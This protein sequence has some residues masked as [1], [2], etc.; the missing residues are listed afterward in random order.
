MYLKDK[1]VLAIGASSD[2]AADLNNKL[3]EAGA[4]IGLHYNKND[5][6]LA[7][8]RDTKTIRKF[9]KDLNSS[10][11]CHE[12][13][14][15]FVKWAGG[16][17]CL[18]Q[19]SGDI[20]NPVHW[21]ELTKEEWGYDLDCNLAMPFFLTQ[22]A[23][24]Y[25]KKHGGRVILMSTASASHG[26]GATSLAYGI[27]KAGIECMVKGLARDCAKYNILVNAVAP[28]FINTK[29]HTEKMHRTKEQLEERVR[30]I[31]LKRAGTTKEFAETV[32]F[33]LSEGASY[34]TGQTIAISGGDWL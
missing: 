25:M 17:D 6:V 2:L 23:A 34:I 21:S 9:Q 12:I 22:R 15:E 30:L 14:D 20:K 16:I 24:S 3:I 8:Y 4:I 7:S 11:A 10:T 5:R 18:I 28:G 19:L 13:V 1:K 33:L 27:A 26:G 31:P 29:F 32:M